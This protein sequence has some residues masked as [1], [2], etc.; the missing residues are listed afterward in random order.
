MADE[1]AHD[2]GVVV[3]FAVAAAVFGVEGW[4][5]RERG[6][7]CGCHGRVQEWEHVVGLVC[8][9]G[10]V[11]WACFLVVGFLLVFLVLLGSRRVRSRRGCVG[12]LGS[13]IVVA[14]RRLRCLFLGFLGWLWF[15]GLGWNN[16][17]RGCRHVSHG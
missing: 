8:L 5:V 3:F 14:R 15:L 2:V 12:G 7:D 6:G 1:A 10:F 13:L 16:F 9:G 17:I 4:W 11:F